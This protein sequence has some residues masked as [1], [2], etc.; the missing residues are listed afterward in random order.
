MNSN[1]PRRWAFTGP[2]LA[3]LTNVEGQYELSFDVS[4]LQ[5]FLDL[6]KRTTMHK[7]QALYEESLG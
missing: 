5:Y 2:W 7:S 4:V 1:V 6:V 3:R